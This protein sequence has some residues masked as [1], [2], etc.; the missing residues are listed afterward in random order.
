MSSVKGDDRMNPLIPI[1]QPI[2]RRKQLSVI[3]MMGNWSHQAA[4]Y[5]LRQQLEQRYVEKALNDK[6]IETKSLNLRWD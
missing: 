3:E 4:V 1:D 5:R 2:H 6:D